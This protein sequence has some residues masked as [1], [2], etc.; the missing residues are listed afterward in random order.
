M[1]VDGVQAFLQKAHVG[2]TCPLLP[3]F[4]Y[5]CHLST[6]VQLIQSLFSFC[7][8]E[9]HF[10]S[11]CLLPWP[12]G[13]KWHFALKGFYNEEARIAVI[14]FKQNFPA[15]LRMEPK[16][17]LTVGTTDRCSTTEW[18]LSPSN[19]TLLRSFDTLVNNLGWFHKC[20]FQ[21][22]MWRQG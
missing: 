10:C 9:K 1:K 21:T 4:K 3:Q 13:E 15:V 17:S 22:V 18:H 5:S 7:R 2:R 16:A 8:S 6:C 11:G 12:P 19:K 20:I 14:F